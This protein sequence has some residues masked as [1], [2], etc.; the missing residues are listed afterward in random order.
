MRTLR[1]FAL[2]HRIERF[3]PFLSFFR[4]N[5]GFIYHVRCLY[6]KLAG[7]Y[8]KLICDLP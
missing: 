6:C 3:Y 2:Q 5:V 4:I 1:T 7:L 8:S